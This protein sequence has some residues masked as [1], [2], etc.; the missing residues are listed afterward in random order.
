MDKSKV[1]QILESEINR[2]TREIEEH[3]KLFKYTGS[4]KQK[5]KMEKHFHKRF[6]TINIAK[7]LGFKFCECC[8]GLK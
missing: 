6:Q 1:K 3:K 2:H 8:G 7:Q 4:K 5:R